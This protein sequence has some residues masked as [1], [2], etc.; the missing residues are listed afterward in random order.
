MTVWHCTPALHVARG[1][2]FGSEDGRSSYAGLALTFWTG[3]YLKP[4]DL[5]D[6]TP[7]Y[8][9]TPPRPRFFGIGGQ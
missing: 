2:D 5:F 7:L 9:A 4:R 3:F 8:Q 6:S 1:E